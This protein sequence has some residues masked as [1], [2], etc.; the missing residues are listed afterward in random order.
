MYPSIAG[1]GT[2]YVINPTVEN[3][4]ISKMD[5]HFKKIN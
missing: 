1:T 2:Y 3:F 4:S 5:V